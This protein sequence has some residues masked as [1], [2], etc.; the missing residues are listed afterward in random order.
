[1][2]D[3]RGEWLKE[4]TFHSGRSTR[5]DGAYGRDILQVVSEEKIA[6][7]ITE[8]RQDQRREEEMHK[9]V[10]VTLDDLFKQIKE[11]QIKE[12][13][14]I[15]KG[16]VQGS[17][18]ALRQSLEKLSTDEVR[19]NMVHTGVG[20]IN[21]NDVML[22]AAS[23]AIIIGFNVLPDHNTRAAEQEQVD[24]RLYR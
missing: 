12:L 2:V 18:E 24:I 17:I 3:H 13:N 10:R 21:E 16:D 15:I 1:M 11:G 22:A 6:R 14:V 8:T 7:Q 4:A 20:T 19:V 9:S 23:N 5:F